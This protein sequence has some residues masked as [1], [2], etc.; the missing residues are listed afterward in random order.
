MRDE[1]LGGGVPFWLDNMLIMV[2]FQTLFW[3]TAGSL[4][5][6]APWA[7]LNLSPSARAKRG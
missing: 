2:T 3:G 1:L 6:R 5:A 7:W 4:A